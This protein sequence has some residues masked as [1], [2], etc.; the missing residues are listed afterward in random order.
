LKIILMKGKKWH[1]A[2][3]INKIRKNLRKKRN[4][5]LG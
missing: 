5:T 1:V 3:F 4:G 2:L